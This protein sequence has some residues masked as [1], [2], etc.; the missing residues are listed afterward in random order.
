MKRLIALLAAIAMV[1]TAVLVRGLLD[2]DSGSGSVEGSEGGD[3]GLELI[4]G[5][6]LVAA[7]NT[8]A[9]EAGGVK[10]TQ[11]P[12]QETA[13]AIATG[14]LE[15]AAGTAWLAAGDW[16]AITAAGDP[17]SAG[18]AIGGLIASEVLARSPAVMV[19]RTDRMDVVTEHC[20]EPDWACV[21][22]AAG[23]SW[24]E[25]G[26]PVGWGRVEVA[27]PDTA[28]GSG[29]TT[30]S[31]AVASEV[32]SSDFA[33]NDLDDPTYSRWIDQLAE[34]SAANAS[35]TSPLVQFVTVPFSLSVVG[36]L[37]SEAIGE[38]ADVATAEELTVVAP[39]PVATADV[40]LWSA[41]E[42]ALA[43]AL[44]RL[45]DIPGALSGSR[46]R[47]AG[48]GVNTAPPELQALEPT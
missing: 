28:T 43:S 20:G 27:L 12:E 25:L 2:D 45:G 41:D 9:S 42:D 32:G 30:T 6:E 15:L 47:V 37:E 13:A 18:S 11:Q 29:M 31:Q 19:A 26:G 8:L 21:G 17:G 1:L 44:E 16:P 48:S 40:R 22:S 34:A 14:E 38:L 35:S 33:T 36:A 4:C 7:C 10:V 24:T 3:E 23:T 46:W 5:P 39:A